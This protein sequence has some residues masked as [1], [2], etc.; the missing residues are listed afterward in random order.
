[1]ADA[2][3]EFEALARALKEAGETGLRRELTKAFQDAARPL[4]RRIASE[5]NLKP[6]MP[7]RYAEILAEDL[8]ITISQR[9]GATYPGVYLRAKG[10]TRS[11]HVKRLN[12][13]ILTHPVFGRPEAEAAASAHG[14]G[15]TWVSQKIRPGYFDDPVR[16]SGPE[17][18]RQIEAALRRVIDKIY[19]R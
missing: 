9:T 10:R 3:T 15:W 4:A 5:E 2:L 11:R 7:D 6:L 12:E 18:R 17:V 13:G 16:A 1:M 14:R 19:A 8:A